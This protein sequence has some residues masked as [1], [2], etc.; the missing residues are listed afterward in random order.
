MNETHHYLDYG[1]DDEFLKIQV[2][3]SDSVER[4]LVSETLIPWEFLAA[5]IAKAKRKAGPRRA[6]K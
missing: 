3:S 1:S 2:W 4:R 6:K 5:G